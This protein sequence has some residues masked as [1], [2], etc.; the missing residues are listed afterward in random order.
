M[1]KLIPVPQRR[2][3]SLVEFGLT[4]S[5]LIIILAGAIDFGVGFFS[6]VAIRDAAQE[7][8]LYGS[9]IYDEDHPGY[10][11]GDFQNM[12]EDRVR[13]SSSA[14]VDLHSANIN[15]Q[16]IPPGT[17]CAGHP[18]KVNVAYI[19]PLTMPIIGIFTGPSITL[20]ASATSTILRPLCP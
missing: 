7:G 8:A 20:R 2:G 18:L 3:Q 19:Y 10:T 4:L 12:I 16:V 1:K 5:L 9:I 13:D 14:P 15:V 6:Y 11:V 17:W